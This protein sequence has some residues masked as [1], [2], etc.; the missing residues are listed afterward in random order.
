MGRFSLPWW[1]RI[2]ERMEPLS[3]SAFNIRNVELPI[4]FLILVMFAA[5]GHANY[6]VY[7]TVGILYPI[8]YS[9]HFLE[10]CSELSILHKYWI[11]YGMVTLL[12]TYF[13]IV[14]SVIPGYNYFKIVYLYMLVR[15]DF[16]LAEQTF[17]LVYEY[18]V[19]ITI[20]YPLC[21]SIIRTLL[22]AISK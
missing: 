3:S 20:M 12:D 22:R 7:N 11:I 1:S 2:R 6:L 14:L 9:L 17:A 16:K 10:R 4:H 21:K 19:K 13:G 18:Y 8:I 5:A 15:N